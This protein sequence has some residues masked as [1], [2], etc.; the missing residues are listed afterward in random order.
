MA[1]NNQHV[2]RFLREVLR[3]GALLVIASLMLYLSTYHLPDPA[4][5]SVLTSSAILL[6]VVAFSH[7][8][9]RIVLPSVDIRHYLAEAHKGNL[10]AAV[11]VAAVI[12][13]FI[14]LVQA[15]VAL[16]R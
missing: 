11:V 9:R 10:A 4:L 8:T 16:L 1:L 6:Y 7:V 3:T 2:R 15:G 12:W 14:S 13:A 5:G